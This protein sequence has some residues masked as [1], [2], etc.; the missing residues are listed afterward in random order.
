MGVLKKRSKKTR[1]R[2]EHIAGDIKDELSDKLDKIGD[3]IDDLNDRKKTSDADVTLLKK[4]ISKVKNKLDVSKDVL[5]SLVRKR[6][7]HNFVDQM[8]DEILEVIHDEISFKEK[9]KEILY[10]NEKIR[11]KLSTSIKK[12]I[13]KD[14]RNGKKG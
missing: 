4:K 5:C 8:T 7:I 13:S 9:I 11:E 12:K 2:E 1:D 3:K 14:K 10:K 6:V